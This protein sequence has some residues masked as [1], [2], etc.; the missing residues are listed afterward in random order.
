VAKPT[1]PV[2]AGKVS[3][4]VPATAGA[5]IVKVPLVKPSIVMLLL[6]IFTLVLSCNNLPVV[7]ENVG[8]A[9]AVDDA[10]PTTFPTFRN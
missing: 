4:V 3:V 7:P 8:M 5:A 6:T 1:V 9:F 2:R 10:G